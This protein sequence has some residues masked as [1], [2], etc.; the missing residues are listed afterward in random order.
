MYYC[1]D[2]KCP[3]TAIPIVRLLRGVASYLAMTRVVKPK[4][5][6]KHE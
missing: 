6:K 5:F 1:C 4:D 3:A 2:S